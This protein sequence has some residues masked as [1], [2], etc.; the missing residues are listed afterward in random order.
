MKVLDMYGCGLPVCAV[1]FACLGELVTNGSNGLVFNSATEL[2][3]QLY[4]LLAPTAAAAEELMRLRNGVATTEARRPRWSDNWRAVAAPLLV[5]DEGVRGRGA[6]FAYL[7][8][9][10]LAFLLAWRIAT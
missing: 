6:T 3:E 5:V 1:G 9:T 8:M 4:H 2:A 7:L 10:M